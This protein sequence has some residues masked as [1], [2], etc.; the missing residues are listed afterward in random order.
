MFLCYD[1]ME[2]QNSDEIP[3]SF[4]NFNLDIQLNSLLLIEL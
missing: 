1:V 3:S 2:E 4:G